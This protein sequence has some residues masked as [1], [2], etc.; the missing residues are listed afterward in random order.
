M[1]LMYPTKNYKNHNIIV[2]RYLS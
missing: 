1:K 2:H